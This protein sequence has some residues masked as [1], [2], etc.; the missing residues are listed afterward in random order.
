VQ[1]TMR[2][3]GLTGHYLHPLDLAS[4]RASGGLDGRI[5]LALNHLLAERARILGGEGFGQAWGADQLGRWIGAV[6]VASQYMDVA[7]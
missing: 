5:H 2:T 1:S 3:T 4:V 6:A 7:E